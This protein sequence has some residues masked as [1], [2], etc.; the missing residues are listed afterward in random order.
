M[1][2]YNH[3]HGIIKGKVLLNLTHINRWIHQVCL[4]CTTLTGYGSFK[5]IRAQPVRSTTVPCRDGYV[6]HI[7][8]NMASFDHK[9]VSIILPQS[10]GFSPI[11][12]GVW[13]I[14]AS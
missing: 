11:L 4:N 3:G 9:W 2:Y 10:V 6:V 5:S 13:K 12:V 1:N 7:K 8:I 14:F